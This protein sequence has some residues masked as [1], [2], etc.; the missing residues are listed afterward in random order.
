MYYQDIKTVAQSCS[1]TDNQS[2]ILTSTVSRMSNPTS[3]D[4]GDVKM[5]GYE[6][7]NIDGLDEE[8]R[9]MSL[10]FAFSYPTT[11]T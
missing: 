10:D 1:E 11:K 8:I 6:L 9:V 7:C 2:I 5:R 3:E 4:S